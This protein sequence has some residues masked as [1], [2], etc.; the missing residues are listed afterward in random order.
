M[1]KKCESEK[2]NL[3]TFKNYPKLDRINNG[4]WV[5]LVK[6]PECLQYWLE[7]LHEPYSSFLFLTKWN[8]DEKEFSRLVE[9]D[10]L[11]QLQ[12]IHD[13]VIID[14][15]KFLPLDEQEAVNSWRKRTYY[16]YN[17]ID[18][19]INKRKTIE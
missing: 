12:E 6:C 9:T 19:D 14:N 3:W 5:S 8:F 4:Y 11:I 18:E 7:S 2:R 17:P 10:D 16:Q 1:C 15:W 13:K